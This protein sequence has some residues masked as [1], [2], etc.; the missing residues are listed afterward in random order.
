MPTSV[1]STG[2]SPINQLIN[3]GQATTA[4]PPVN[5]LNPNDFLTLLTAQLR[6]Q[7]PLSPIDDTQSVTELAQF[8]SVS[9]ANQLAQNFAAFQSNFAV[10]QSASLI[11]QTVTVSTPDGT[12]NSSTVTGVVSGV[13]VINGSPQLS[14]SGPRG[15][16]TDQNGNPIT[17]PTTAILGITPGRSTGTGG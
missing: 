6:N 16:I 11:G 7:N 12:G 1:G 10:T 13:T 14:L 3:S 5:Q 15:P 2:T 4:S 8:E 17:F 9:S